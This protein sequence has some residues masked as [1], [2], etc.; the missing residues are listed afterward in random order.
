MLLERFVHRALDRLGD[1][2]LAALERLLAQPDPDIIEWIAS[3][4]AVPPPELR[5]IVA[6]IRSA[7]LGRPRVRR[8]ALHSRR[9]PAPPERTMDPA[10]L[11]TADE[12]DAV[13]E[14]AMAAEPAA[15]G[16]SAT[17]AELATVDEPDAVGE[18]AMAAEPAAVDEPDAASSAG[19]ARAMLT[20]DAVSRLGFLTV[21]R[22]C[23]ADALAFL[24]GQ[25]TAD[26]GEVGARVSRSAAWCS[27]RGRVLALFRL[28]ADPAG[29]YRIVCER[30]VAATLLARLRMFI[31]RS[32]VRIDD[33]GDELEVAGFAGVRALP[34]RLAG[35]AGTAG[36]D[37]A[38]VFGEAT[39]TRVPGRHRRF[40]VIGPPACIDSI[41]S[42]RVAGGVGRAGASAWRLADICAGVPRITAG[43][44]GAFLPQMLNLDRLRAVS[45]E[46]GCY[47]G[48]EI[49]A[50]A[51]HLGRVKRRAYF[52]RTSAAAEG[53]P[54]VDTAVDGAPKVGDV[55]AAEPHPDGGSAVFAVLGTASAHSPGLRTRDPGGPPVRISPHDDPMSPS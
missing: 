30:W 55:V 12:P 52:G 42:A 46:K 23:G 7:A 32:D 3:T 14:S 16:E 20:G 26:I 13:D 41:E 43:S 36:V 37:D 21:R 6:L 29:G 24:Q 39:I 4:T 33:P 54:V 1:G 45:F 47:V 5:G 31:L 49:V 48:Q 25:L 40:L 51:Q 10:E 19:A 34:D 2:D 9:R 11:A 22:V 35:W 27:A 28:F 8:G 50:R 53:D 15:V 38:A 44:S 18:L 17:A